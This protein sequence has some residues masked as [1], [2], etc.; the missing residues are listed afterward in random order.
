MAGTVV[1]QGSQ[2]ATM[3]ALVAAVDAAGRRAHR[4]LPIMIDGLN[5]AEDPRDWKVLLASLD[6]ILK[7]YPYALVV[8]TA[9]PGFADE[10]L[11]DT[12][13][14]LEIPDFGEDAIQARR[15]YFGHY[16]I[17]VSDAALPL[18][19]LNHPLILR[20]F[21]EITNPKRQDEVGV[22]AIPWSLTALF[23]RYLHDAA[24]RIAELSSRAYR[25]YEQ[26]VR[27]AL[28]ELGTV[29]WEEKCRDLSL[30][31]LR[32]RLGDANRPWN[33]SLAQALEQDG[34]L[35]RVSRGT[36]EQP[37]VAVVYDA[38][39]GHLISDA[40]LAQH[41][42]SGFEA[43]LRDPCILMALGGSRPE[44]HPLAADML[45]AFVGLVP[46]KF[47]KQHFWAFVDEP[48]R[49][50]ALR[51]AAD[52][53]GTY[54]DSETVD[55]LVNLV[56]HDPVDSRRLFDRLKQTQ[57]S[58]DHPL[59]SDFLERALRPLDVA[60]RDIRWT[61]WLR[62]NNMHIVT[63]L[64]VWQETWRGRLQR[65][66]AD[67]LRAEWAKWVLTTTM[68]E[69]RD[70]ATESLYWYGCGAAEEL[71][72]MTVES[73]SIND[74]YVYERLLAA[75]YGV[76]MANQFP[77]RDFA[78]T[79]GRYLQG[80][81]NALLMPSATHPTNDQLARLYVQDTIS[82]AE[83]FCPD[84]VPVSCNEIEEESTLPFMSATTVSPLEEGDVRRE[85]V[86]QTLHMDFRNYT[87]GWLFDDRMN[88]DMDHLGH[89]AAV[90][91]VLGTVWSL[92]WRKDLLGSVDVILDR[93]RSRGEPSE[94]YGKKYGWIGFRTYAGVLRGQEDETARGAF[95][96]QLIDPSF[97]DELSQAPVHLPAWTKSTPIDDPSWLR[98][99]KTDVPHDFLKPSV[100][101]DYHGPWI[102]VSGYL[103]DKRQ[104]LGREVF[105][106]VTALLVNPDQEDELISTLRGWNHSS[107]FWIP[108]VPRTYLTFAG[109]IP[110]SPRFLIDEGEGPLYVHQFRIN[111]DSSIEVEVLS[112]F[113]TWEGWGPL[114]YPQAPVPAESFSAAFSL[115]GIPQTLDQ[116]L[117]DGTRASRTLGAPQGFS[118][119]L[120]YLRE[121][122]VRDYAKERKLIW[123][124]RGERLLRNLPRQAPQW[125]KKIR[126][127]QDYVWRHVIRHSDP[128]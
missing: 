71:F 45:R 52:L 1:I 43:W 31:V 30:S 47:Y 115:R 64:R 116:A 88:Y 103:A 2:V 35:L 3:E 86:D 67:R 12:I 58:P 37:R 107:T 55:A 59:N 44:Q 4:R 78:I 10:A 41:G 85:E 7:R 87:I 109:E 77:S 24:K 128:R 105:G 36:V 118:G 19:D 90:A 95:A 46:R 121:D 69:L 68:G 14:R 15:L 74:P 49:T 8:G 100:I 96:D 113:Y 126:R 125:L 108:N 101:D 84:Q 50:A 102:A 70:Q 94:R 79:L 76:V 63:Q 11:P 22:E 57:S 53:E 62:Q 106:F 93:P 56:R 97:P 111:G 13:G 51:E 123:F 98:A 91:H 40:M 9:R 112:H 66:P 27:S 33:Q 114:G 29:L 6:E 75:S 110:W 48:L 38:L 80:L 82:F 60:A 104:E 124:I 99:G 26:D 61:E 89:K 120:L 32:Q 34:I 127:N 72:E 39:A 73:L 18:V 81:A 83:K 23:E 25:Y 21:C 65:G 42:S 17:N 28:A 122:L 16:R 119:H 117:P 92:G 54:I 5:E 20:M